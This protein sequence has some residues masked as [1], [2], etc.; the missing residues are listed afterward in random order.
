MDHLNSLEDLPANFIAKEKA[1]FWYARW[2]AA[3]LRWGM[4][5]PGGGG[6]SG[7]ACHTAG[8]CVWGGSISGCRLEVLNGLKASDTLTEVGS[9]PLHCV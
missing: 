5:G 9:G 7:G 2:R 8:V 3:W 4:A 1:R 6:R